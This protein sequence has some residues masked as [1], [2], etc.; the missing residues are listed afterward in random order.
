M[1]FYRKKST[2]IP[3]FVGSQV[4]SLFKCFAYS[5]F[6]DGEPPVKKLR[7]ADEEERRGKILWL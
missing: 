3:S 5:F 6:S 2:A 1:A 4:S 7:S